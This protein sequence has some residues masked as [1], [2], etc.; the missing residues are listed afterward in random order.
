MAMLKNNQISVTMGMKQVTLIIAHST[1]DSDPCHFGTLTLMQSIE[2]LLMP[3][4]FVD[5]PVSI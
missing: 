1:G 2:R 5:L 3:T 4:C